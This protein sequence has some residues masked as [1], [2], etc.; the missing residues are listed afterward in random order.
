MSMGKGQN[1]WRT[2]RVSIGVGLFIGLLGAL[3]V[4][5]LIERGSSSDGTGATPEQNRTFAVVLLVCMAVGGA[6]APVVM[7]RRMR[8]RDAKDASG[9][10]AHTS[11]TANTSPQ[12]AS[13][14]SGAGSLATTSQT[15][16]GGESS[17]TNLSFHV[18]SHPQ[19]YQPPIIERPQEEDP[20]DSEALISVLEDLYTQKTPQEILP[21]IL[22]DIVQRAPVKSTR[23]FKLSAYRSE[24]PVGAE[25]TCAAGWTFYFVRED[26]RLGCIAIVTGRE[27]S[28]QFG[29]TVDVEVPFSLGEMDA[30]VDPNELVLPDLQQA[31]ALVR[32]GVE[33]A[34]EMGLYARVSLPDTVLLYRREPIA[35]AEVVRVGTRLIFRNAE[36]FAERLAQTKEAS[37][38]IERWPVD[39]ISAWWREAPI[40]NSALAAVAEREGARIAFESGDLVFYRRLGRGLFNEHG[41]ATTRVVEQA[42]LAAI[43]EEATE[44]AKMLTRVLAFVPVGTAIARLHTLANTHDESVRSTA[45]RMYIARRSRTLGA[46]FEPVEALNFKEL[47]AAMGRPDVHS[48]TLHSETFDIRKSLLAKLAE[49]RL[50]THRLRVITSRRSPR[51]NE[52]GEHNIVARKGLITGA[53]LRAAEGGDCEGLLVVIPTPVPVYVLHLAGSA[54]ET[55]VQRVRRQGLVYTRE[56]LLEGLKQRERKHLPALHLAVSYVKLWDPEDL[57][58]DIGELL[59]GAYRE[60]PRVWQLRQSIIEALEYI[61]VTET[62]SVDAPSPA[63]PEEGSEQ[64]ADDTATSGVAPVDVFLETELEQLRNPVTKQEHTLV[65]RMREVRARRRGERITTVQTAI[66]MTGVHELLVEDPAE[67]ESFE[68]GPVEVVEPP[69]GDAT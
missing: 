55:F 7:V 14:A 42:I 12:T 26:E 63:L 50:P 32:E 9:T 18:V 66:S 25:G 33:E 68:S 56:M 35:I 62:L 28:L 31:L 49:I 21:R 44:E 47:Y 13:H 38:A 4:G 45:Q 51:S 43:R 16:T 67:D 69:E 2:F 30:A 57:P 58:E 65:A 52:K 36:G 11:P 59:I 64:D 54:A 39:A 37:G 23:P 15:H 27:L 1:W 17:T 40:E 20:N 8:R 22:K 5:N 6:A 3:A 61:P 48:V 60:F 10:G 19:P 53:Y 29:S 46:R 24:G 34:A 41:S